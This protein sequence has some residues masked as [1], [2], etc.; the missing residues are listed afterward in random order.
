MAHIITV[1]I[2]EQN[3]TRKDGTD[4]TYTNKKNEV[5]LIATVMTEKGDKNNGVPHTF[6]RVFLPPYIKRGDV[7]TIIGETK[8]EVKDGY[9]NRSF[10]FPTIMKAYIAE[11]LGNNQPTQPDNNPFGAT[12]PVEIAD[13]DLPF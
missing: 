1:Q 3:T 4:S 5:G 6:A 7:V 12:D 11:S 2:T 10:N 13:D 8:L 9:V